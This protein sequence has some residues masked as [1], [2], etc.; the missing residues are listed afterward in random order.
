MLRRLNEVITRPCGAIFPNADS[1]LRLV[2][3]LSV[4]TH[5]NWC[6]QHRYLNTGDLRGYTKRRCAVPPDPRPV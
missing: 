4:D 2:W 1:C 5:E 6:E 3:A